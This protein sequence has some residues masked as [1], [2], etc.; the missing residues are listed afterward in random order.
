MLAKQAQRRAQDPEVFRA[1]YR[2]NVENDPERLKARK[3]A[4]YLRN[5]EKVLAQAKEYAARKREEKQAALTDEQRRAAQEEREKERVASAQRA[6]EN[7]KARAKAQYRKKS[8][9]MRS[10]RAYWRTAEFKARRSRNRRHT[11]PEVLAVYQEARRIQGE[12]GISC[13]VDHILPLIHP[14]VCGLHV[15]A[16]LQVL[17]TKENARKHTKIML[18]DLPDFADWHEESVHVAQQELETRIFFIEHIRRLRDGCG[19]PEMSS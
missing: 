11:D 19:L 3:K 14:K 1:Y 15:A 16:N 7:R 12:Y 8:D 6:A 9:E 2:T 4:T 5:R 17:T 13:A 18:R 10:Y